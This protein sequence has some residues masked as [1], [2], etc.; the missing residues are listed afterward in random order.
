LLLPELGLKAEPQSLQQLLSLLD[1]H[2]HVQASLHRGGLSLNAAKKLGKIA[3]SEQELIVQVIEDLCLGG[4]KQ[5]KVIERLFTL[6]QRRQVGAAEVLRPWQEEEC[7]QENNIPQRGAR[8]LFYL[9]QLCQPRLHEAEEQFR[10]FCR[11]LKLPA[12]VNL[13]HSPAFEEDWVR[14]HIEFPNTEA[15]AAT[16]LRLR[17]NL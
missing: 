11:A 4:S 9:E 17:E 16:W 3:K 2:P 5:Q 14:L 7:R 13:S 6:M 8:L 1:L 10:C 15:L 12:G